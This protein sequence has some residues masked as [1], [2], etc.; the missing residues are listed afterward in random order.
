MGA[1]GWWLFLK[2]FQVY[3]WIA[4]LKRGNPKPESKQHKLETDLSCCHP[5][6]RGMHS[7]KFRPQKKNGPQR[8]EGQTL[9]SAC[10]LLRSRCGTLLILPASAHT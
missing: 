7:G 8:I 2:V 1:P 4:P 5:S 9:T 3:A 6:A 10:A